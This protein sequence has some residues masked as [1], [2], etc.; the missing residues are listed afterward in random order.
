MSWVAIIVIILQLRF[1][2]PQVTRLDYFNEEKR[3]MELRK[4]LWEY[5]C[6]MR[7]WFVFAYIHISIRLNTTIKIKSRKLPNYSIPRDGTKEELMGLCLPLEALVCMY[8][9][10][11]VQISVRIDITIYIESGSDRR[12]AFQEMEPRKNL[13]DY[14]CHLR[15]WFMLVC[16]AFLAI[17]CMKYWC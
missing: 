4:N 7:L 16:M 1:R 6:H 13:W 3:E 12:K 2:K 17:Y 11:Y 9:C 5:V 15:R 10:M 14:V 8:V